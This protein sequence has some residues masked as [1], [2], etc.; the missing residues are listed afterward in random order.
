MIMKVSKEQAK[1][2]LIT[3]QLLCMQPKS[4]YDGIKFVFDS[5][6]VVQ[7][8]PL[9]P[10]GRNPDLV[11]QARVANYHPGEYEQ[12]LYDK[13]QGIE[14]YDKL[15]CIIP[16]EDLS[17]TN[18]NI[19]KVKEYYE[20]KFFLSEKKREFEELLIFIEKNGPVSSKDIGSTERIPGTGWHGKGERWG[21]IAL[22]VLWR[23]GQVVISK[24][25]KGTKHYDLPHKVYECDYFGAAMDIGEKHILRRVT[26]VGMLSVTRSEATWSGLGE[27][28]KVVSFIKA[29]LEKGEL[30]VVEIDDVKTKYLVLTKDIAIFEEIP[31]FRDE[32]IFIA[33]LDTLIWDRRLIEE[34]FG[35]RYRWEVYVPATKRQFGYYV[36]PIL[37]KD[38]FVGRIEPVLQ[39]K[40]LII[41]NLWKEDGVNWTK[42]MDKKLDAAINKFREYV[43]ADFVT[44]AY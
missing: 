29:L 35:F 19:K 17:Y 32:M 11:L 43:K 26:S 3:K 30:T 12:W 5:L 27:T 1:R 25:I 23:T 9:N 34:I 10:C 39:G 44:R 2:F 37:Y 22:E 42:A 38:R 31:N 21:K 16:I 13:R 24:R 36:L 6:R 15:L 41:K 40:T 20:T 7:Y 4:G 8:D 18:H 14:S 28:A 33:P